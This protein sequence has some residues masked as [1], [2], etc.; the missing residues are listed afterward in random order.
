M[1]KNR[2][3]GKRMPTDSGPGSGDGSAS[4]SAQAAVSALHPVAAI[5]G[6][7]KG[8]FVIPE[9]VYAAAPEFIRSPFGQ[10][11]YSK[12]SRPIA[13][14]VPN[15]IVE[16][17]SYDIAGIKTKGVTTAGQP[18]NYLLPGTILTQWFVWY[19]KDLE[20]LNKHRSAVLTLADTT[21]FA[22]YWNT[23]HDAVA[24]CVTL[25]S[26]A[27]LRQFNPGLIALTNYLTDSQVA[28]AV[29]LWRR[30]SAIRAP[31]ALKAKAIVDGIPIAGLHDRSIIVRLWRN[32]FFGLTPVAAYT[33]M[34]NPATEYLGTA[35]AS[36]EIYLANLG[37]SVAVL[38]GSRT[39]GS[40]A[41]LTAMLDL[42]NMGSYFDKTAMTFQQGLPQEYD[43]PAFRTDVQA[44]N[45]LLARAVILTDTKGAGTDQLICYP[46]LGITELASLIPVH[47]WGEPGIEEFTLLGTIKAG[48][49]DSTLNKPYCDAGQE[50]M[51]F[52]TDR[53]VPD[54]AN[55]TL[56]DSDFGREMYAWTLEDG[57]K[58][59]T[60]KMDYGDGPTVA[61][62]IA[63]DE[64]G[65]YALQHI[66]KEA[67]W[68]AQAAG[69]FEE[70]FMD[71]RRVNYTMYVPMEDL[72]LNYA[73]Y[74][75]QVFGVPGLIS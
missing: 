66:Y 3:K 63:G 37:Q 13:D 2:N 17:W 40:Q 44:W 75:S 69:N 29:A 36:I 35:L 32:E 31:A 12:R 1:P 5:P 38:E 55:A 34:A 73:S 56:S 21:V 64:S 18:Y 51:L 43:W 70:R 49:L 48:L 8:P 11:Y 9:Y 62:L 19:R 60:L 23:Y 65:C 6:A 25:L 7:L 39:A 28:R 72:C 30:L 58:W 33:V 54:F 4:D 24:G 59:I 52:G 15:V 50:W 26:L 14:D 57:W 22:K 16:G 74:L 41:D 47:G 67:M 68:V 53:P 42:I 46:G 45:S 10:A 71:L 20:A 61:S 27:R